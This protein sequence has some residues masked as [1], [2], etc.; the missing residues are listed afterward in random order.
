MGHGALDCAVVWKWMG[1]RADFITV[2]DDGIVPRLI[3]TIPPG[4]RVAEV[5]RSC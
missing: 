3:Q 1:K 4:R 2:Y 5:I